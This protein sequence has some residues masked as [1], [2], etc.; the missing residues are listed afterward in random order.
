MAALGCKT[1]SDLQK[2]D[3]DKFLQATVA[4][5]LRVWAERDG[6]IL[7]LDPYEA[8][9]NGAAKDIDLLHGCNKDEMGYFIYGF[10][11]DYWN[12]W[13][14]DRKAKKLAQLTNEEKALVES[15]CQDVK[16]ATAEY[17]ATS[18][19]FDQITFIAP[20]IR[21]SE[22]QTKSGGKSYTYFFTPES[23]LPLLRCGHS[24]EL[25]V[26]FNHQE[27]TLEMGWTFDAT[28]SKTM[29]R[30]WVQFAKTGN[31][32]LSADQSPDGKAKEWPLYDLEN[33]QL[34]IF[35]EFNIHPEKESQRKIL[36][37]DRTYFLTKYYCI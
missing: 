11:L 33:K 37:W 25:P 10:G 12:P 28:F 19:L 35:D 15:Y 5:G 7:P 9:A 36:D 14:A 3:I 34:M 2:V 8:Y 29:R 21:L 31:P 23:S 4:V 13:A 27:I 32:S 17:S 22:N 18:R 16:D 1:V 30:M 6:R 24:V 20:L 26:I